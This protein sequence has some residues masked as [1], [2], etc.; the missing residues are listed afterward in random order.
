MN[1]MWDEA[2]REANLEQFDFDLADARELFGYWY[3]IT[4]RRIARR[5]ARGALYA[6]TALGYVQGC[7]AA[8]VYR[9]RASTCILISARLATNDE[10]RAF[11]EYLISH[12]LG[13]LGPDDR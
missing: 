8:V 7:V 4:G 6:N 5:G 12:E 2:D 9:R 3:F 1:F 13:P 10:K 11:E